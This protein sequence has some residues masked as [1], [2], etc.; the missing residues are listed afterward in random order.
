MTFK[1]ETVEANQIKNVSKIHLK[2]T[3]MKGK[4]IILTLLIVLK[5]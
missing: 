2:S 4:M 3:T 1:V 5:G